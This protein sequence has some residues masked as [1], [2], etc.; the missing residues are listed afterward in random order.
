MRTIT[1]FALFL[2]FLC[3]IPAFAVAE[4]YT[5]TDLG[6]LSPTGIN[7]WGQV[8]G[9]YNGHAYVWTKTHGMQDLGLL[10]GGTFSRATEINDLGKVVGTAHGPGTVV[11]L[12]P[13][14]PHLEC[15]DLTQPFVWSPRKGMQ[16]LGTVAGPSLSPWDF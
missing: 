12:I 4:R 2:C 14:F 10:P 15:S 16:G 1:S 13:P 5:V 3:L 9:N 8:V 6:P 11:S 7:T